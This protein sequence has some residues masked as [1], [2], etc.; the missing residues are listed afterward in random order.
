MN[1]KIDQVCALSELDIF[2]KPIYQ[3]SVNRYKYVSINPSGDIQKGT[4]PMTFNINKSENEYIDL[5]NI[6][7]Y[8]KCSIRKIGDNSLLA[9]NVAVSPVN[10]F[11]HSLF[12]EIQLIINDKSDKPLITS[13]YPIKSFYENL[14]NYG[15]EGKSAHLQSELF[16]KDD[17]KFMNITTLTKQEVKNE[18][19]TSSLQQNKVNKDVFNAADT[20]STMNEDD[21]ESTIE[22]DI[23]TTS[24]VKYAANAGLVFRKKRFD[25]RECKMYGKL[26]ADLFSYNKY[27]PNTISN[28]TIIMK[29]NDDK[30]LLK[31]EDNTAKLYTVQIESIYLDV[32]KVSIDNDVLLA[33]SATLAKG[34]NIILPFSKVVIDKRKIETQSKEVTLANLYPDKFPKRLII[35]FVANE[36]ASSHTANP[37]N[38]EFFKLKEIKFKIDNDTFKSYEF[39]EKFQSIKAYHSLFTDTGINISDSSID[40]SLEEHSSGYGLIAVDLSRDGCS[41]EVH[42]NLDRKGTFDIELKFSDALSAPIWAVIYNEYNSLLQIDNFKNVIF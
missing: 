19:Q 29:K 13:N 35:G 38:F 27:F 17:H 32:K 18:A 36:A 15:S 6:F 1:T 2:Q 10:N 3:T 31:G 8:V 12:S 16:I 40:I 4:L 11:M 39:D 42:F 24:V 26:H 33:H 37:I 23:K 25:V 7:C 34:H 5:S 30:F 41:S 22:V 20:D 28:L 14:L 21:G 9:S